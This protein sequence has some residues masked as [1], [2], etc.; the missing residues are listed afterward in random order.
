MTRTLNR[1]LWRSSC[2]SGSQAETNADDPT[3]ETDPKED[4]TERRLSHDVNAA[5]EV[6]VES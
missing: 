2:A 5:Q 1:R 3:S 4:K 6:H